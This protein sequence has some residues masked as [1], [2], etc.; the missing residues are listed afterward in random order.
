[1]GDSIINELSLAFLLY[2]ATVLKTGKMGR[3]IGL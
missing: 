3:G 1:M 2:E